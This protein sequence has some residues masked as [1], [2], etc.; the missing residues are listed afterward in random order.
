M[1]TDGAPN[2]GS[3]GSWG[4]PYKWWTG[5][6]DNATD[7]DT[8]GRYDSANGLLVA[9]IAAYQ[10]KLVE[11]NYFGVIPENQSD[12]GTQIYNFGLCLDDPNPE[13]AKNENT[14]KDGQI[15]LADLNPTS[16]DP[17]SDFWDY[18]SDRWKDFWNG[19][20]KKY[21][22]S[23]LDYLKTI[24]G[25]WNTYTSNSNR[26]TP[27]IFTKGTGYTMTHPSANDI[28]SLD[29]PTEFYSI[30]DPDALPT[31]LRKLIIDEFMPDTFSPISGANQ[32]GVENSLSYIDF[33]GKYMEVKTVK[34]VLLF[35]ELYD[36]EI[37]GD[38]RYYKEKKNK[39][40]GEDDIELYYDENSEKYY[41][42]NDNGDTV[43]VDT[44]DYIRQYYKINKDETITNLSYGKNS[45][46]KFNLSDIEI[47]V[48]KT[49][50]YRDSNVE[51]GGMLS[52]AGSDQSLY[53]NIPVNAL[54][55]QVARIKLDTDGNFL[56]YETNVVDDEEEGSAEYIRKKKQSTPIRVFYEVGITEEIQTRNHNVDMTKVDPDY[57]NNNKDKN[58]NVYFYS[59][60]YNKN[61]YGDY[62]TGDA[63][64]TYG[65]PVLT[66][67]PSE[68]NRYYIFQ[69]ALPLYENPGD[70]TGGVV[71]GSDTAG[72][73][74]TK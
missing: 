40:K 44:Y 7:K 13:T 42:V 37:Y 21:S 11:Q 67:S 36:V 38:E 16:L 57:I 24:T 30:N 14:Y 26:G 61:T 15:S 47:Y 58:G 33:I 55:M 63:Q 70:T 4:Y 32:V 41:Y 6:K 1:V 68:E 10:K 71:T 43:I 25:W 28:D 8:I 22:Y 3:S 53:I 50:T 52:D 69:K 48:M 74:L 18:E 35:G 19:V 2:P 9:A 39:D 34:N 72:W 62:V 73:T 60:W 23:D 49:D 27:V 12:Y 64:Y 29:Y 20:E 46:K 59:N 17:N 45:S 66:F 5:N 54:P 31:R 65:D 56:N 51:D